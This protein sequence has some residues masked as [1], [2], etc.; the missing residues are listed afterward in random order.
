MSLNPK[1][2]LIPFGV[3]LYV[4]GVSYFNHGDNHHS[5][6][7]EQLSP[8]VTHQRGE[9]TVDSA[10][11]GQ[12]PQP[13]P[14]THHALQVC[15]FR[16]RTAMLKL[17]AKVVRGQENNRQQTEIPEAPGFYT[18]GQKAS[19]TSPRASLPKLCS[20]WKRTTFPIGAEDCSSNQGTPVAALPCQ[21]LPTSSRGPI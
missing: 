12:G 14:V 15:L 7:A 6:S 3:Q 2:G 13:A 21:N 9:L 10:A 20:G 5:I 16:F 4:K 18:T 11:S 1:G 8:F 19:D 17:G